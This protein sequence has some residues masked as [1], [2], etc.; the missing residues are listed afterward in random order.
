MITKMP[1]N[2]SVEM[3]RHL[4]TR[5]N[6]L[7]RLCSIWRS[8]Q[9]DDVSN[10]DVTP[11]S[12][13]LEINGKVIPASDIENALKAIAQA[14]NTALIDGT[15]RF[16]GT[17]RIPFGTRLIGHSFER[18]ILLHDGN[19]AAIDVVEPCHLD[20]FTLNGGRTSTSR[21]KSQG[22]SLLAIHGVGRISDQNESRL[23]DVYIGRLRVVQ[24]DC[25][26]AVTL[27]NLV[28]LEVKHLEFYSC[29]GNALLVFG[30]KNSSI[31]TVIAHDI[32]NT[33]KSGTR[34]GS[35]VAV[36]AER[37]SGKSPGL[38][39]LPSSEA[40][41]DNLFFGR[42]ECSATS[43]TA[44]Y[45]HGYP[46]GASVKNVT[47]EDVIIDGAGKD[48]WKTRY[49]TRD[50]RVKRAVIRN[51]ALKALVI[52]DSISVEIDNVLISGAGIDISPGAGLSPVHSE[53]ETTGQSIVAQPC[54]ILIWKSK[55]V[56]IRNASV[57]GVKKSKITRK[58]GL[59]I[60]IVEANGVDLRAD[61]YDTE[62]EALW[63]NKVSQSAVFIA[64]K[65]VRRAE[66]D[67]VADDVTG[68]DGETVVTY[69]DSVINGKKNVD[70]R[71]N[72]AGLRFIQIK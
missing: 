40:E 22:G 53:V 16:T 4:I 61:V 8:T 13:L 36:F 45:V 57:H 65:T 38:W 67:I 54:G 60:Y 42:T 47:F 33:A 19:G 70:R 50:I 20:N 66:N 41:T 11:L 6:L 35:G 64:A 10:A 59:G 3:S 14:G 34:Q 69:S 25:S 1:I 63:I 26:A 24:T 62:G 9:I 30:L 43:D 37:S 7:I 18:S 46:D 71:G 17:V 32:G 68:E 12:S 15:F 58:Y 52:E 28:G 5:R 21:E 31:R 48:G 49:F 27:A 23:S 51:V 39:Y 72:T 55:F 44:I 2:S 56:T 29:W